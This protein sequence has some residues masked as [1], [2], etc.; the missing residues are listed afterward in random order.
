MSHIY[1]LIVVCHSNIYR[2][3]RVIVLPKFEFQSYLGAIQRFKIVNLYLVPPIIITMTKNKTVMDKYDLS[4]VCSIFTGAAPLGGETAQ[5]LQ[6]IFPSWA[7]KQGY[8]LTESCTVVCATDPRDI[9]YG[10]SGSLLPGYEAKIMSPEGKEITEYDVPG[11]LVVRSP[12]VTLGYL[13]N[14]KATEET[15]IDEDGGRWAKT[16][17]E[18]V[19]RK[20]E[21]SGNE[22][23]WIVDRIKELI[24]VKVRHSYLSFW[25]GGCLQGFFI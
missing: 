24:K 11:E 13:H 17:D 19:V 22:H 20:S 10:S 15:F 3:D 18:A 8:G 1:G 9:V 14:K 25:I 2:G 21:K 6:N 7:V 16:G 5:D 23:I 4:S 12:S